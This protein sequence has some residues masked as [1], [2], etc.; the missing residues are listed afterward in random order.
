M[1][2]TGVFISSP[3]AELEIVEKVGSV[4]DNEAVRVCKVTPFEAKVHLPYEILH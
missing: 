2:L 3:P 4:A 1:L